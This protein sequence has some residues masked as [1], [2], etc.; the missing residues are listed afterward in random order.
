MIR[1]LQ[2]PRILY[3]LGQTENLPDPYPE[4]LFGDNPSGWAFGRMGQIYM[5]KSEPLRGA[6]SVL[7]FR[8][9]P[10]AQRSH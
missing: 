1:G 10:A 7:H 9:A 6:R 4:F 3:F 8:R 2:G 5:G